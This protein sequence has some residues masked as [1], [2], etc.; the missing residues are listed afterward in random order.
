MIPILNIGTFITSI[1]SLLITLKLNSTR[2][3]TRDVSMKENIRHFMGTW[4]FVALFFA[5]ESLPALVIND[6]QLIQKV[7][8][9]AYIALFMAAFNIFVTSLVMTSFYPVKDRFKLIIFLIIVTSTIL[10]LIYSTPPFI[11]T[12]NNTFYH[13]AEGTPIWLQN[14]NGIVVALL[15]LMG[16]LLYFRETIRG[17]ERWIRIRAMFIGTGQICFAFAALSYFVIAPHVFR[18]STAGILGMIAVLLS[19]LGAASLLL[20]ILFKK[21]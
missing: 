8:I 21:E 7:Y 13:W 14:I 12:I 16:S 2:Q 18:S 10:N 11:I 1:C 15:T 17:K 4:L 9:I 6:P 20:G 3:Q 5:I 19:I